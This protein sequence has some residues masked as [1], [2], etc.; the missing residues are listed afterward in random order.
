MDVSNYNQSIAKDALNL[1]GKISYELHCLGVR[2]VT[3]SLCHC[4]P[5]RVRRIRHCF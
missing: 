3:L 2:R 5:L 1:H 4:P